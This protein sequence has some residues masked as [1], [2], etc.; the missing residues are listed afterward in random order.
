MNDQTTPTYIDEAW[1]AHAHK[2]EELNAAIEVRQW[3]CG[4][5][6]RHEA[7]LQGLAEQASDALPW[8]PEVE[9]ASRA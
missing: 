6:E 3:V 8:G 9:G 2:L 7:E 5:I 4:I 1:A